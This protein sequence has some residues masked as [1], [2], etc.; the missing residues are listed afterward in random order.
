[1]VV[2]VITYISQSPS[3]TSCREGARKHE[4]KVAMTLVTVTVLIMMTEL[5]QCPLS[6]PTG[7]RLETE[8]MTAETRRVETPASGGLPRCQ[9]EPQTNSKNNIYFNHNNIS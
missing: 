2:M 3:T 5:A 1:M 7:R 4:A 8:L 9:A 6:D